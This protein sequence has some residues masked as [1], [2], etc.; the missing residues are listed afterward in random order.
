MPARSNDLTQEFLIGS[1][2][3]AVIL[4]T[5]WYDCCL[6]QM[7]RRFLVQTVFREGRPLHEIPYDIAMDITSYQRIG[8]H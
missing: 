4:S 8:L 2:P 7:V 3:D 1:R 6:P 5:D